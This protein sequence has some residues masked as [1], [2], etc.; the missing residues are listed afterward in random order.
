MK[1]AGLRPVEIWTPEVR[2]HEATQRAFRE[3]SDILDLPEH[4]VGEIIHGALVTHPR[5]GPKHLLASS[6][7]GDELICPVHKGRGGPG[8]W[9]I[10]DERELHLK[11][12]I[13][14]PDLAGWRRERF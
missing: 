13:L 1:R 2:P 9:W 11:S 12:H 3:L 4:L 10:L 8:G 5:P 7:L 6:S 14:V